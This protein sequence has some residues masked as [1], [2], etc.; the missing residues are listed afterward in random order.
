LPGRNIVLYSALLEEVNSEN[1]LAF[2]LAHELGHFQN[3]DH[4][5]A[6]GRGLVLLAISVVLFG[7]DSSL[8]QLIMNSLAGVNMK[9]SQR[10]ERAA[11]LLAADLLNEKYGHV[12]GAYDF[13]E[14]IGAKSKVGPFSH[15]LAS[16]P[17]PQDRLDA[18]R[19]H[20]R[21]KEYPQGEKTSL[22]SAI[23]E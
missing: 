10:Q 8:S 17:S 18:L 11:D 12:G 5:R 6:L 19:E 16:H 2:V 4:L 3:R 13:L 22:D 1:E 7:E 15:Y 21:R 20:I 14:N 9:F 23:K